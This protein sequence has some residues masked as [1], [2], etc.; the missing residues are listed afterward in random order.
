MKQGHDDLTLEDKKEILQEV[1]QIVKESNSGFEFE[2]Q[3]EPS[4]IYVFASRKHGNVRDEEP[5]EQDMIDA[6]SI[7]NRIDKET[8]AWS[9]TIYY[10]DEWVYIEVNII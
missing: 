3:E 5:G 8:D 4:S 9:T 10:I 6:K 7:K 1:L 2:E